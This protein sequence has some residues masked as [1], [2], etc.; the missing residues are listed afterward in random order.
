M[1][2]VLLAA[3]N[4]PAGHRPLL[5]EAV[6]TTTRRAHRRCGRGS[7]CCWSTQAR[8]LAG[9]TLPSAGEVFVIVGPRAASPRRGRAP[10]LSR[11]SPRAL[12]EHRPAIS[13]AGP[14]ALAV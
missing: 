6:T 11:G 12:G 1:G 10:L 13:S 8:P 3:T 2:P 4:G 14:A 9:L 5:G 7:H